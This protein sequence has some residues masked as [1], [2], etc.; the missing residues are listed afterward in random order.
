MPVESSPGVVEKYK[1]TLFCFKNVNEAIP[2]IRNVS[3]FNYHCT[4]FPKLLD[5]FLIKI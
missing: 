4:K 5:I 1:G 3:I 2:K